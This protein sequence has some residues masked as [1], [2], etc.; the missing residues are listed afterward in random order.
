MPDMTRFGV[1]LRASVEGNTLHGHAAVFDQMADLPGHYEV[2]A[3]GVFDNV[4]QDATTDVRALLNHDPRLLLGRQSARTLRLDTDERGLAF[5][6]DLPD[7]SY[8]RDLRT[9]VDRGDLNGASFAFIPGEDEWDR[10]PDGRQRRT[11]TSAKALLDVSAVTFPAYEGAGVALRHMTF[12]RTN[13]GRSQLIR[14]RHKALIATGG[15]HDR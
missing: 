6:V 1:E 10:A 13:R 5:E 7:T 14:A 3:R 4:L 9:L 15:N 8:A 2:L 12:E 11:H